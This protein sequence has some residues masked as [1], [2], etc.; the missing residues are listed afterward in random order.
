MFIVFE[1]TPGSGKSY[2]A[3][4]KV[5]DNL[6]LGR[7]IYTNI[8]GLDDQICREQI[9]FLAELSDLQLS[10]QL[11]FVPE[12][13]LKTFYL[14][15][16]Q[17]SF[18]IIDE[19]HKW[20]GNRN[21]S[22]EENTAFSKWASTHRHG[23]Y[24]VLLLTQGIEKIDS[25]IRGL[26]EWTYRFKKNNMFGSF[27]ERTY[28][29]TAFY[30]DDIA[31]PIDRAK[32]RTYQSKYFGCYKSYVS[33]D[34]KELKI[35]PNINIF[36]HPLFYSI[37]VILIFTLYMLFFKSS[38]GSGDLFGAKKTLKSYEKAKLSMNTTE[39]K[40]DIAAI[41]HIE[42]GAVIVSTE[43]HK[44]EIQQ[45]AKLKPD[46]NEDTRKYCGYIIID[47]VRRDVLCKSI[48][49]QNTGVLSAFETPL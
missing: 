40:P 11:K 4:I 26:I 23:G 15:A 17:G 42:T 13:E 31:H 1:G 45:M 33:K 34:V 43:V 39:K 3:I 25:H 16:D 12:K 10:M 9:K 6:K 28:K 7:V 5:I 48:T 41:K 44:P 29:V 30:Q 47:D 8:E 35:M 32:I 18:I 19:V 27:A 2:E 24:D 14:T 21:W 37:P 22:S 36:K 20:F 38:I 49:N 46:R